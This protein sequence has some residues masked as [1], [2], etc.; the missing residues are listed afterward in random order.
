MKSIWVYWS[1]ID[2]VQKKWIWPSELFNFCEYFS[3]KSI[4]YLCILRVVKFL[5]ES[6]TWLKFSLMTGSLHIIFIMSLG[7]FCLFRATPT[8]YGG[9][10]AS[11]PVGAV[12]SG[13]H[14]SHRTWDLSCVCDLQLMA[15]SLTLWARLG[16]KP[17]SS[18]IPVGFVSRWAM[19][20]TL[21]VWNLLV[22]FISI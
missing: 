2:S 6:D 7:L 22:V 10:Q 8:A 12:A 1:K 14:H 13:L 17:V 18:W 3:M 20:G 4:M 9:S 21:W 11:G 16:I 19:K 15:R 5:A